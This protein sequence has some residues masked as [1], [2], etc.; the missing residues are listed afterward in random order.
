MLLFVFMAK[1]KNFIFA[2]LFCG[3]FTSCDM[4]KQVQQ[5]SNLVNCQ[6]RVQSVNQL[7]FAGVNVQNIQNPSQLNLTDA[8][9]LTA[10]IA[11]GK[12]L[13]LTFT[14][15][16]EGKNPNS[17]SAGISKLDWILL[18]DDIEMTQG[19]INERFTI[20]SQNTAT[21]PMTMKVDLRQA[22]TGKSSDAL[23]NFALNLAGAGSSPTRIALKIKPT[24]M[25][26]SVPFTFSNYITIRNEFSSLK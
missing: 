1:Q 20:P 18:I 24:L 7:A 10:A 5:T 23:L 3:L 22:L 19:I 21:L 4:W 25:I 26:G 12:E 11:S 2:L 6:F 8:A 15:N 17:A 16:L 14:L 13:P 9:K